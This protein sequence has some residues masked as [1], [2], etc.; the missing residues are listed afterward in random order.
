MNMWNLKKKTKQTLLIGLSISLVCLLSSCG[1][2]EAPDTGSGTTQP[3]SPQ[4]AVSRERAEPERS[5][6][7]KS[8]GNKKESRIRAIIL[9]PPNPRTDSRITV[10]ADISPRLNP[11][12]GE[13]LSFVFY[14][15]T[16]IFKEQ[17]ENALPPGSV[18]K[19]ESLFADVILVKDGEE[20]EK[21]RTGIIFILNS[22]PEIGE[23]EFP[24]ITGLGTYQIL[25][26]ASDADDDTLTYT[27]DAKYGIPEGMEI[28]RASGMI[29]YRISR[30]PEKDVKFKVL[31][32]DGDGG[33][34]WRELF[35]RFS[36]PG[37]RR[38]AEDE[39]TGETFAP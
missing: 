25:V 32:N 36:Q 21:K 31:V 39:E 27:L 16:E 37:S 11:D 17:E 4:P 2:S 38:V 10:V 9:S 26:N 28:D 23:V 8:S 14:K 15:N 3:L 24:E 6:A 35:I 22:K 12:E 5:P 1:K 30:P 7:E 33:E 34:D 29:T 19:G 13:N 20:I 18:V